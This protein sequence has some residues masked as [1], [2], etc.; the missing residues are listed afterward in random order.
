[1]VSVDDQTEFTDVTVSEWILNRIFNDGT[2]L[3]SLSESN[4]F[5]WYSDYEIGMLVS[6]VVAYYRKHHVQPTKDAII[7]NLQYLSESGRL[8][9]ELPS[10]IGRFTRVIEQK[11]NID[12]GTVKDSIEMFVKK[13]GMYQS[14]MKFM[15]SKTGTGRPSKKVT[16]DMTF[17]EIQQFNEFKIDNDV[18]MV[19]FDDFDKHLQF[20]RNPSERLPTGI[21]WIDKV[22]NGGIYR[23]D[24]FMGI[25]QAA[26]CVGKS[27]LL[28]QFAYRSLLMDRT[29]LIISCEMSANAYAR[30]IDALV[31]KGCNIDL[32]SVQHRELEQKVRAFHAEHPKAKLIIKEYASGKATTFEIRNYIEN[33]IRDGVKPDLIVLDYLNLLKTTQGGKNDQLFIKIGYISKEIRAISHDLHIPIMTATQSNRAAYTNSEVRLDNIS[34]S[35]ALAED[36]DFICGLYQMDEDVDNGIVKINVIKNRLGNK[37]YTPHQF[38]IDDS[39]LDLVDMGDAVSSDDGGIDAATMVSARID[40]KT[41]KHAVVADS[42][43]AQ[44]QKPIVEDNTFT[45]S[46]TLSCEDLGFSDIF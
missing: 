15:D 43:S 22:T 7:G 35:T 10:I 40:A 3:D 36:G 27:M 20:I 17:K 13:N 29:V 30:R 31:A 26:P 21:E 46:A 37:N 4:D 45:K 23:Y 18:G 9:C 34:Q 24:T 44:R 16:F 39:S 8:E 41:A 32:L 38:K 42:H 28:A 1:M 2:A 19:Y 5:N 12:E 14:F 6:L 33:L 25:I 11:I